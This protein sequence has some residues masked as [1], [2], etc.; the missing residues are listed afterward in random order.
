MRNFVECCIGGDGPVPDM[1]ITR[2]MPLEPGDVLLA[3]SDGLWSGISDQEIAR[4]ATRAEESLADNL[5]ALSVRA[6]TANAPYSDN[7]TGTLVRWLG[8]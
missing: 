1:S 2:K 7:T 3:C 6:L 8:D 4:V 5:K